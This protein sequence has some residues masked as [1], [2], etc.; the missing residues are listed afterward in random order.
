[1]PDI[2]SQRLFLFGKLILYVGIQSL[3]FKKSIF[4]AENKKVNK[5]ASFLV[6]PLF[7]SLCVHLSA[8]F[9]LFASKI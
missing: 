6:D 1:M 3:W 9:K 5:K 8:H 7:P 2:K 4:F